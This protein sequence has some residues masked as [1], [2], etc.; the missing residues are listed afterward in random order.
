[1]VFL[2]LCILVLARPKLI[3]Q[4][5]KVQKRRFF[6]LALKCFVNFGRYLNSKGVNQ[7]DLNLISRA[8]TSMIILKKMSLIFYME[9]SRE[10]SLKMFPHQWLFAL[11]S[12][13]LIICITILREY[14]LRYIFNIINSLTMIKCGG[15]FGN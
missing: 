4:N 13:V 3:C 6:K 5:M 14:F 8:H 15:I 10:G 2:G 1:M 7:L 12:N 9:Q 11:C